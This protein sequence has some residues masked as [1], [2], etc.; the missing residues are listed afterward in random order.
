MGKPNSRD[1]VEDNGVYY[2]PTL[3]S[4]L[5]T[6]NSISVHQCSSVVPK[7]G[8]SWECAEVRL[9]IQDKHRE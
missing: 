6:L 9:P 7:A 1:T 4:Q 8:T 2:L 3:N 5:S